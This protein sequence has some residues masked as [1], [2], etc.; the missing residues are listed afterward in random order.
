MPGFFLFSVDLEDVRS[1]IPDGMNYKEAV[2]RCT[3]LY[4]DWLD[5]VNARA[6][7]FV[8]GETAE[9]YPGLNRE[10]SERGHE[11][12]CHTYAH[13]LVF[14]HS[15]ESFEADII[16]NK[17]A[18]LQSVDVPLRGFRAPMHSLTEQTKWAYPILKKQGFV[19]SSSVVPINYPFPGWPGFHRASWQE[20]IYEMPLPTA[21]PGVSLPFSGGVYFRVL[22]FA[23]LPLLFNRFKDPNGSV[24]SYLH[25]YDVDE[26]QERFMH[27]NLNNNRFFNH[28]MYLNRNQVFSRLNRLLRKGWKILPYHRFLQETGIITEL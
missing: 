8:V 13:S 25:P 7:F 11:L 9:A 27:P 16:R 5:E 22:P 28:L 23:L 20:G 12:A 14:D 26:Q 19:Y 10:I 17:E 3:R 24:V 1:L 4:L 21:R 18:I 6:T 2:P 15:P